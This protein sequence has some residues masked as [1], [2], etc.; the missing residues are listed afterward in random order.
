M[1][2]TTWTIRD[3]QISARGAKSCMLEDMSKEDR[4]IRFT[5]G[6]KDSPTQ[7]P[8][9]AT[10]YNGEDAKRQTI[11]FYLTP[12][13]ESDFQAVVGWAHDYLAAHSDRL[14][15]KAMTAQQMS[16]SF[17]SPVTQKDKYRPHLRCKI[18]TS[19]KYAV[20]CWD[21]DGN[22]RDRLANAALCC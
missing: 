13:Q 17:G 14:F 16:D 5:L 18:D 20:R 22:R 6:G 19:G 21:A 8:F 7:T 1:N 4:R 9:G 12:Q 2:P 10:T 15:R 3:P 11:E